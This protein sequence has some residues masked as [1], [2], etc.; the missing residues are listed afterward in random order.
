MLLPKVEALKSTFVV[1][2]SQFTGRIVGGAFGK[3]GLRSL[4][5]L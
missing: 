1:L 5:T 2:Y 4:G 3:A